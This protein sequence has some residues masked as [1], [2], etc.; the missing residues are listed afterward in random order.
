MNSA[1]ATE[2]I[3]SLVKNYGDRLNIGAGTVCDLNDLDKAL[4][5]GAQFIVTP[6]LDEE[7]IRACVAAN[8][9]VFPGAFTPTEILKAWKLGATMV[10]VFP[11]S[12]L[13]PEFIKELLAPLN[14]LKLLPTGG[15]NLQ[16]FREYFNAGAQG[17]GIGSGLFPAELINNGRW[18][19][20]KQLY[21][22]VVQ[23][24]SACVSL[25]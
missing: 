15:I 21:E 3:A 16:N 23:E 9:P 24:I 13:G 8:I 25:S 14:Y 22:Q 18:E 5:A 12:K 10:K 17:V 7:V 1:G 6:I 19:E 11:A 20:L 2:T 4:L